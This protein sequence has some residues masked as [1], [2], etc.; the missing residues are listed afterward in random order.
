MKQLLLRSNVKLVNF[1]TILFQSAR[2]KEFRVNLYNM[3]TISME[4]E[5][6]LKR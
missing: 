6:S 1:E 3:L 4:I 2:I 5:K